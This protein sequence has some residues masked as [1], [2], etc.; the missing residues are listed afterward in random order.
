MPCVRNGRRDALSGWP[1][2]HPRFIPSTFQ[3][4]VRRVTVKLALC[5]RFVWINIIYYSYIIY[6]NYMIVV[7]IVCIH[8]V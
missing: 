4:Q 6:I 7:V 3:I 2:S 5:I 1:L 8:S